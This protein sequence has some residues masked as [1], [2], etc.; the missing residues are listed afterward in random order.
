MSQSSRLRLADHRAL[1]ELVNECRELGDDVTVWRNHYFSGLSRFTGAGVVVGGEFTGCLGRRP[2]IVGIADWGWENGFSR[3][4]WMWALREY[5]QDPSFTPLLVEYY[6]RLSAADGVALTRADLM[7]DP[8]WYRSTYY[9]GVHSAIRADHTMHCYRSLGGDHHV[10]VTLA[11]LNGERDFSTRD[12]T[13]VSELQRLVAPL[14]GGALAGFTEPSPMELAPRVR[15]VLACLLEGDSDKQVA[16][17]LRLSVFTVNQYV[18][19]IFTHFGVS[20]RPELLARWIRRGW[21]NKGGWR[22]NV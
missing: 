11:R 5:R 12:R 6:R 22:P 8:T 1:W 14:I 16:A 18:K 13:V 19:V 20:S 9:T 21:G 2:R 4:G 15:A 7:T 10:S 3:D 17:R